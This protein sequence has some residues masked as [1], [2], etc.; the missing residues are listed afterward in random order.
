MNA[1][2]LVGLAVAGLAA[3]EALPA[4]QQARVDALAQHA[5]DT[6]GA[7]SA[8]I[9]IVENDRLVY[10][11]AYGQGRIQPPEAATT[12]MRYSIGSISKQFTAAAVL[13]LQEQGRLK[14]DDR[15]SKYLPGFTRAN[16][17][18]LRELLSH[19]SGYED[20][21]PQDYMIP[22]WLQPTTP[23][24]VVNHWAKLPL[25]FD[26]GTKWQYSNT[27]YKLAGLVVEKVSGE[28]LFQFLTAHIFQP[29]GMT[30]IINLNRTWLGPE[31][32]QGTVRHALGP[33][34][35]ADHTAPG[36][37]FG[38]GE[39]AMT[40]TMLAQWQISQLRQSVLKPA[41]YRQLETEVPLNNGTP[42]GYALGL[43]VG[44]RNGHRFYSHSGEE[45]GFEAMEYVFPDDHAAVV[46]LTNQSAN[47]TAPVLA[48]AIADAILPPAAAEPG[49]DATAAARAVFLGLQHGQIDRAGFTANANFY[50]N[51]QTLADFRDSLGP[52]GTPLSFTLLRQSER[53]GMTFRA[54]R[55]TFPSRSVEIST[56]AM[57]GGQW[58][59]FLVLPDSN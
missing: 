18:T 16:E 19:T 56:Y 37:D 49:E 10:A 47:N 54:F 41:S 33:A 4:G 38:D 42:T 28:P 58:E 29:L 8:S 24:A 48:G 6:L 9:A 3:Q 12:A 36:W 59:Q 55:A 22:A 15:L 2:F 23:Q 43:D 50:F 39:L 13:L 25:N 32:A 34:R 30:G 35:V 21:A 51:A 5:L 57:P 45:I 27:N 1:F 40:P 17:V 53:G 11:H 26:P 44:R 52:L 14:L 7:P 20:Y 31:D 46:V